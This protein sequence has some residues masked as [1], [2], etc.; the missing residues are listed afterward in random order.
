MRRAIFLPISTFKPSRNNYKPN[1]IFFFQIGLTFLGFSEPNEQQLILFHTSILKGKRDIKC[2]YSALN[3][4]LYREK[5]QCL[6]RTIIEPATTSH[7]AHRALFVTKFPHVMSSSKYQNL[8]NSY[9]RKEKYTK[10]EDKCILYLIP[11]TTVS[12]ARKFDKSIS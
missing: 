1:E 11:Q 8:P 4:W 7:Y 3:K 9:L 5:Y 12:S 2:S 6:F 10:G